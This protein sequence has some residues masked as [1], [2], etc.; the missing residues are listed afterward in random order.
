MASILAPSDRKENFAVNCNWFMPSL[1]VRRC[2]SPQAH[3]LRARAICGVLLAFFLLPV[4][5]PFFNLGSESTL[6]A[7]CR[8]DGKHQCVMSA[9]FQQAVPSASSEPVVRAVTPACPYRSRLLMPIVSRVLFVPSAPAFSVSGVSS[10]ALGVETI[11][12][13]RVSEF[14]SHLKRGPPSLLT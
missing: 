9:R 12:V 8:R 5:I 1:V 10:A 6:P 4:F 7:C 11:R 3:S 13:A 2:D 14:R